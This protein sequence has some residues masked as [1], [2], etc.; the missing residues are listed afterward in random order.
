MHTHTAHNPI[1]RRRRLLSRFN[2]AMA[3]CTMAFGLLWLGWIFITLFTE[4]FSGIGGHIFSMDTPPP[5]VAGGLRNA[6]TGSL[7][8]TLFGLLV[9]T[10][11]GILCGIYLA[12]FG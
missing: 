5:G 7:L 10:P 12:E 2:L 6:V 3:W 9:G 4:G 1:Y 8:I 11:V